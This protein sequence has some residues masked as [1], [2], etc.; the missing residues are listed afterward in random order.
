MSEPEGETKRQW[1]AIFD[2]AAPTYDHHASSYFAHAGARLAD[3]VKP[4]RGARIL[5]VACGR[6]AALFAAMEHAGPTGAGLGTD[7]SPVMVESVVGEAAQRGLTNVN[8]AVMD[9]ENL[10]L[11]DA[12][13]DVV[14]SA[15]S[16]HFLPSPERA[17]VEFRRVLRPGGVVGI[18]EWGATD[19]RWHWEDDLIRRFGMSRPR[20]TRPFDRVEDV[21]GL[22]QTA[23][24]EDIRPNAEQWTIHLADEE[25]WWQWKWSFAFRRHLEAMS[26]ETLERYRKA[27][28]DAMRP[29]RGPGGYERVLHASFIVAVKP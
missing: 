17:A 27:A 11:S 28:A 26:P 24:F 29:L 8:A 1:A 18:S 22:L 6:G 25:E 23:G 20:V 10:D 15:F 21:T 3:Y 2:R 7:I 14:L 9:A 4:T 16:L 5:D 12:S 13:F 19:P